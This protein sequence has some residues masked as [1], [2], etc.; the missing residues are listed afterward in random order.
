ME[1]SGIRR[2]GGKTKKEK[3]EGEIKEMEKR[4]GGLLEQGVGGKRGTRGRGE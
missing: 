4:A 2:E 1:W 3:R